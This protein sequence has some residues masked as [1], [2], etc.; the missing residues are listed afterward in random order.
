MSIDPYVLLKSDVADFTNIFESLVSA[1]DVH[2]KTPKLVFPT[3]QQHI[4]TTKTTDELISQ[5]Y[6]LIKTEEIS[7]T[8]CVKFSRAINQAIAALDDFKSL[9]ILLK[10]KCEDDGKEILN[11]RNTTLDLIIEKE[12]QRCEEE[13]KKNTT[14]KARLRDKFEDKEFQIKALKKSSIFP[15]VS[16]SSKIEKVDNCDDEETLEIPNDDTQIEKL[17]NSTISTQPTKSNLVNRLTRS[18]ST[19]SKIEKVEIPIVSPQPTKS[20]VINKLT[21]SKLPKSTKSKIDKVAILKPKESQRKSNSSKA[22]VVVEEVSDSSDIEVTGDELSSQFK[23]K[24]KMRRK[25]RIERDEKTSNNTQTVSSN[26]STS[27]TDDNPNAQSDDSETVSASSKLKKSKLKKSSRNFGKSKKSKLKKK[28]EQVELLEDRF[29]EL[30]AEEDKTQFTALTGL[31]V[32]ECLY[33][34]PKYASSIVSHKFIDSIQLTNGFVIFVKAE[35]SLFGVAVFADINKTNEYCED[36]EAFLFMLNKHGK[37]E[38]RMF[39]V[40]LKENAFLLGRFHG[41]KFFEAGEGDLKVWRKRP[42]NEMVVQCIKNA[43]QYNEEDLSIFG[44]E[45]KERIPVDRF[46]VY[47]LM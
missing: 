28:V 1:L 15:I 42:G 30:L 40:D 44:N 12:R 11:F 38:P 5:F 36:K 22:P 26:V 29:V 37:H 8:N 10:R 41:F 45:A 2:T 3:Q 27:S 19:K 31:K 13:S 23:E 9:L 24:D 34:Y 33:D 46:A 4:E 39:E 21:R 16:N 32:Y 7:E 14:R 17:E 6:E 47:S 18:N 43:Y 25:R 35:S 20:D